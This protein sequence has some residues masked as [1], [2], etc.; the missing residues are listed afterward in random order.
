MSKS[1]L[2][3]ALFAITAS[4]IAIQCLS[5]PQTWLSMISPNTASLYA[6]ADGTHQGISLDA[7][8]SWLQFH[9]TL[10][11]LLLFTLTL[12]LV[13]SYKRLKLLA[14][15]IVFSGFLQAM[16]AL[17]LNLSGISYSV[18]EYTYSIT[19][20]NIPSSARATGF[21]SNPD[22]LA[23]WLEM[24]LAV[25]IGLLISML[26]DQNF[27]NWRQRLR[28]YSQTILGPKARLRFILVILCITLV[29]THSRMG[30]SA[31]FASLIIAGSM[32]IF[33]SRHAA[34][35]V[36]IFLTSLII[37]D[38]IIIGSWFGLSRVIERIN[39]TTTIT[40]AQ[41]GD[42][43]AD[44]FA[45]IHDFS[46]T[47]IGA[48]NFFS[49]FPAYK[50]QGPSYYIDHVHND[51]LEFTLNL[52]L[53]GTAPLFLLLLLC[54]WTIIHNLRKRRSSLILGINFASLMGITSILIHSSVDFNLQVPANAALFTMLVALPFVSRNLKAS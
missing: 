12:I 2:A 24:S 30:N 5:I 26:S 28:H 1:W 7:S 15:I 41:R 39:Q 49:A 13:D 9:K 34:K 43:Y 42:V 20:M 17:L 3:I 14:Y 40:E 38:I 22:H 18:N 19:D 35:S 23:G 32:F 16:A 37:I 8:I 21:N 54:L 11:L 6:F 10:A 29:M 44:T 45:M 4:W 31:F 33:L 53:I 50:I 47:G 51:F 25:G 27:R 36:T 52:G 48:G 46:L